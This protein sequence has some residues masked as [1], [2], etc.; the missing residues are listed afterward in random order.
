MLGLQNE[1][2]WVSFCDKVLQRPGA[3]D[4]PALRRQLQARWPSATR[5]AQIIVEA[6]AALTAAQVVE[7]LEAAQIANARVNDDARRVGAPATEGAR[8]LARGRHAGGPGARAAAARHAGTSSPRMDPVPA[9]GEH[10]DAI[11]AEL[12]YDAHEI[13]RASRIEAV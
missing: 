3:G 1:R 11:L 4:R 5:C 9:L 12:G 8:P 7:R 2:E 6:F 10:T 13:A